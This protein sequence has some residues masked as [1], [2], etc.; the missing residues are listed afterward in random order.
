[1]D[2]FDRAKGALLG[3]A[4]GDALG[5]PL[6]FEERDANPVVSEMIGGGP[7]DLKSGEWTDDT[8]MA[9]C[10]ADSLI[11]NP[12][13]DERDLMRR[14]VRWWRKGETSVNDVCFDI[15]MT[16]ESAL[17]RFEETGEVFVNPDPNRAGNGSLMRLA[18]VAI[19]AGGDVDRAVDLARRQSACT[20]GAPVC[21]DACGLYAELLVE[22]ISGAPKREVLGRRPVLFGH[23]DVA[24]IALGSYRVKK[25]HEIRSTGFVLA[26]LEA[27][28]WAIWNSDSFEEALIKAI[29]LAGDADTVGA[30]TGQLAGAIYGTSNIP[31]GWLDV[32]A[33]RGTL[34]ER[35]EALSS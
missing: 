12:Q 7:F 34:E 20:H 24:A 17:S 31:S 11:A 25:R 6:E 33:C 13:L 28:L 9:L 29:N 8:S 19:A 14:F 21:L 35:A 27:A 26:T 16:T 3:L 18:P 10:L 5:V 2:S 23:D 32:L 30:V 15:G 4:V 1:M 22:A